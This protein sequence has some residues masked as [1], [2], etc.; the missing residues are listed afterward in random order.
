MRDLDDPRKQ[1]GANKIARGKRFC[2]VKMDFKA[3]LD[4][5]QAQIAHEAQVDSGQF[6]QVCFCVS[7]FVSTQ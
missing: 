7:A 3:L 2:S 1:S 4:N 5:I 6:A